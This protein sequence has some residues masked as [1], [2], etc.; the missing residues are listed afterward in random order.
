MGA[1]GRQWWLGRFDL[2]FKQALLFE[3][4]DEFHRRHP[5]LR[6]DKAPATAVALRYFR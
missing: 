2:F 6:L 5:M 4:I 3:C 1:G